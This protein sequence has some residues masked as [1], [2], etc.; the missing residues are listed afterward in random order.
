[1][2]ST[3]G[4]AGGSSRT[5]IPSLHS[6]ST[7]ACTEPFGFGGDCL[8]EMIPAP[9]V[10]RD[11]PR[12]HEVMKRARALRVPLEVVTGSAPGWANPG[13]GSGGRASSRTRE[14]ATGRAGSRVRIDGKRPA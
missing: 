1:M 11:E 3:R 4:S 7:G 13:L 10:H 14:G 9:W 2:V 6:T 8:D 5:P 12:L